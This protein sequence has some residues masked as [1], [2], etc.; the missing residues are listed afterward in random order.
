MHVHTR[1]ESVPASD[2]FAPSS[3]PSASQM[4]ENMHARPTIAHTTVR[5]SFA[6]AALFAPSIST[7]LNDRAP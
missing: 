6:P 4:P 3:C 2:T 5:T 1:M 7:P